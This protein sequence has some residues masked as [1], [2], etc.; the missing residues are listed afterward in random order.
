MTTPA[1][2]PATLAQLT[3]LL[4]QVV[5]F[6]AHA[7]VEVTEVLDGRAT[8][9]LEPT[10]H[11]CNHVGTVHAGALFTLAEAASGAAMSGVLAERI[12]E[13]APV[14]RTAAITYRRPASG[15]LLAT[16]QVGREPDEIRADLDEAGRTDVAVAVTVH[17]GDTEVATMQVDWVV[18][19][20][21]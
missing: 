8:A 6:A 12:L 18:L 21:G 14:V 19:A 20:P 16:G 5:P 7:D 11:H 17:A 10:D 4:G 3:E 1:P 2:S 15:S 9:R 13:F